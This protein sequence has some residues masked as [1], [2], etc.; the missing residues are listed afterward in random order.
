MAI[1]NVASPFVLKP[2]LE[3]QPEEMATGL[4]INL[5]GAF[6]FSQL[7]LPQLLEAGGGSMI[8]TGATASLK[9]G[10]K[11]AAFAPSKFAL[12]GLGQLTVRGSMA[13]GQELICR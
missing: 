1:F 11:F 7:A 6:H 13:G 9:G 12:R 3:I 4:A 10:A 8:F 2:F 5:T